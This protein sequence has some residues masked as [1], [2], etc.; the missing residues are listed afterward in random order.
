MNCR[1]SPLSRNMPSYFEA[2]YPS[3]KDRRAYL[4]ARITGAKPSYGHLALAT[5]MRAQLTRLVWTTNFDPLVADACAKVYGTTGPLTTVALDAPELAAQCIA[6]ER[7]PVEVKLH[8]DFHSR[9]LKNTPDE[10]R[11]QDARLRQLLVDSCRRFGLVVVGY[12]DD[13]VM[14]ALEAALQQTDAFPAGLFWLHRGEAPPLARV[15]RLLADATKATVEAALV[16][17]ENFD[18]ALRDLMRLMKGVDTLTLDAFAME[19]R[20]W[21]SAPRPGGSRG[22]PVVRLNALPVTQM[23]SVCRRVG[24]QVGGHTEVRHAILQAQVSVLAARAQAG[25]LAFGADADV[26]TA[27]EAHNITEFDLHT[28]ETRRLRY[29][30]G[31]RGLLRDALIRAI[32]RQRGLDH[33]RRRSTDLLVPSDLKHVSWMPLLRLVGTLGGTVAG[34]PELRWREGIGTRLDWADDRLWLL[35][36]PRIVFDGITD[37]NKAAAAD[38]ARERTV[39]RYNREL[40][41]LIAFWSALLAGDGRELRALGVADGVDAVFRLSPDTAFSRRARA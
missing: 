37:E 1:A 27:F 31:E 9:R 21:S 39:K 12:S 41:D 29:E 32:V 18:E 24:C 20:R 30:S 38:F 11:N 4:D 19:R 5:L 15:A 7:W 34:H 3:E 13:S 22:W 14:D 10:L 6:G 2:V 40:N 35:V 17:V 25:V 36:E 26:R 28:I 23:P 16:P 33:Q 8:G